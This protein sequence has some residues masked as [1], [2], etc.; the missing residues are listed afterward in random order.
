[1]ILSGEKNVR[2]LAANKETIFRLKKPLENSS[3]GKTKLS[4]SAVQ[5][6]PIIQPPLS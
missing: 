3:C 5:D 1:M 4:E 6:V 2:W